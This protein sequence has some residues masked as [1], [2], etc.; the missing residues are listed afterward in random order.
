MP[1]FWI[2]WRREALLCWTLLHIHTPLLK[3]IP[4]QP[5]NSL[6]FN[7]KPI[8]IKNICQDFQLNQSI[9]HRHSMVQLSLD[10]IFPP[11]FQLSQKK[12]KPPAL[13]NT[14]SSHNSPD[15]SSHDQIKPTNDPTT[16][17]SLQQQL[18]RSKLDKIQSQND[19]TGPS[20]VGQ[21]EV[22]TT[23]LLL[24]KISVGNNIF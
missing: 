12:H 19:P 20:S 5:C 14:N 23:K 8:S 13:P 15:F 6:S 7:I 1:G 22:Q 10:E 2:I 11:I 18:Q 24:Q 16:S 21:A 9:H 17:F 3:P 4:Y